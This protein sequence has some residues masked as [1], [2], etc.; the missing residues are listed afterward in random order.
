MNE[1][2][3][4][5]IERYRT[6]EALGADKSIPVTEAVRHVADMIRQDYTAAADYAASRTKRKEAVAKRL[7]E[8]RKR[9]DL[10]QQDVAAQTGINVVTLSGYEIGK[11][12]PNME[13]L[14]R[15]ADAYEVTLDYLMCRTDIDG[16]PSPLTSS[17]SDK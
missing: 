13:A 14:V 2:K 7:H 5:L 3:E 10:K 9:H 6:A 11:N 15:L 12:E 17:A 1:V 4:A 8:E 16:N